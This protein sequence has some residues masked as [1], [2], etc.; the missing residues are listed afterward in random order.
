MAHGTADALIPLERSR[1][2][3]NALQALGYTVEW[4]EYQMAHAVCPEEIAHI[5]RWLT[6]VLAAK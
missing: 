6:R 3:V 5:S 4:H 1:R 2:A